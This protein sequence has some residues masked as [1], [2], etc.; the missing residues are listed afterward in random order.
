MEQITG[1]RLGAGRGMEQIAG[2]HAAWARMRTS[3][4]MRPRMSALRQVSGELTI[5]VIGPHD[6]VERVMLAG[7]SAAG[8]QG[9]AGP[10]RAGQA[11]CRGGLPGRA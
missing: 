6:F 2:S 10:G 4:G 5:G 7:T 1:A 9:A 3:N 8:Y 11:A